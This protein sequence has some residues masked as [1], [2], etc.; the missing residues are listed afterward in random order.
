MKRLFFIF[1]GFIALLLVTN[2]S[3]FQKDTISIKVDQTDYVTND[4]PVFAK[5]KVPEKFS[6]LSSDEVGIRLKTASKNT[7]LPGQLLSSDDGLQT[8]CWLL[9]RTNQEKATKWKAEFYKKEK[10]G[11]GEFEWEET[12]GK[13]AELYFDGR[14]IFRYCYELDDHFE[15]GK[16]LTANNKVFYHIYDLDGDDYITN[17]PEEGVWS[18]HRGIMTGWRDIWHEGKKLSFWGMEDLTVQKHIEFKELSGGPVAAKVVS[19]IH[20]NDSTGLTLI[21]EIR[22][23][24]IYHQPEPGIMLLDF[25]SELTAVDGPLRLDGNADHG[26]TQFRAHNDVAEGIEGS[27]KAGYYFHKEGI[28]PY[29]D[30]DLPWVG[31]DYGLRDKTYSVLDIDHPGN[32][33][34]SMWSAYRDYARFGPFFIYELGKNETLEVN[35]RF[36]I[37]ESEMPDREML[38][39]KSK[40]YVDP[41][42]VSVKQ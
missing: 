20:W 36:W 7:L 33:K 24:I 13:Y 1:F 37:S 34:P 18:H 21:K 22:T 35:Y 40:G 19:E 30:F 32:P 23:A 28:D 38:D 12:P 25:T 10:P 2:C 29:K 8:L 3:L 42:A 16:T 6:A 14:K 41:P 31:M 26:G 11:N 17:G 39:A 9:P 5:V 27:K 15:K 4:L